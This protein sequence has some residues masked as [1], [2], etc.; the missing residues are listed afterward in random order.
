M[1]VRFLLLD[2]A[3]PWSRTRTGP[4][5]SAPVRWGRVALAGPGKSRWPWR[6]SWAPLGLRAPRRPWRFVGLH[7]GSGF[8][9]GEGARLR[10]SPVPIPDY[11]MAGPRPVQVGGRRRR[12][13]AVG[14][15]AVFRGRAWS[16]P[17][18]SPGGKPGGAAV[19]GGGLGRCGLTGLE[20]HSEAGDG[21][22][23]RLGAPAQAGV[24]DGLRRRGG[25]DAPGGPGGPLA[26]RRAGCWPWRSASRA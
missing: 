8:P 17:G 19:P 24:D 14:T 5:D 7:K 20:R 3:R 2:P 1:V 26:G 15:L 25:P 6:S 11:A 23:H 13:G 18:R 16:W 22:L 9:P 21:P 4:D 10:R 12:R